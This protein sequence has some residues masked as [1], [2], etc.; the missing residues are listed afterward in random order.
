MVDTMAVLQCSH[1]IFNVFVLKLVLVFKI[2]SESLQVFFLIDKYKN[3]GCSFLL[4]L[5]LFFLE[6]QHIEL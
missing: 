2:Y 1:L 4:Q 6:L 3:K 5:N